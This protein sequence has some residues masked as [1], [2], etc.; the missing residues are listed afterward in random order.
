M[1]GASLLV[2]AGVPVVVVDDQFENAAKAGL[3]M[4]RD[5][6]AMMLGSAYT[7]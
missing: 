6:H 2:R 1:V 7:D 5:E 3:P 4:V